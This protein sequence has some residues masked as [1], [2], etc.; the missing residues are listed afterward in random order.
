MDCVEFSIECYSEV[1]SNKFIDRCEPKYVR[2]QPTVQLT[3]S[4]CNDVFENRQVSHIWSQFVPPLCIFRLKN[5]YSIEIRFQLT[6][7]IQPNLA[8]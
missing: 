1:Q 5:D 2:S 6:M 3:F 4:F 7:T 8:G